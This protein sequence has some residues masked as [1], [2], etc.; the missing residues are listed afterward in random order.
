MS[1]AELFKGSF[2]LLLLDSG[3][4]LILGATRESLP[5]ELA[6]EKVQNDVADGLQVVSSRLLDA[7][8]GRNGGVPGRSSQVLAVL[9]R[10]VLTFT[11]FVALCEAEVDDVDVVLGGLCATDQEVVWLDVSVDDSL[12][13]HL[14]NA[15]NHL[16]CD[17]EDS[18]QVE[19][20]LAGL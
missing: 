4:L 13:M 20:P 3:V 14:F 9:V 12:L 19:A 18:L 2:N 10:D 11:V 6:L 8:V 7:L 15:T 16:D 1:A 5:G 17:H